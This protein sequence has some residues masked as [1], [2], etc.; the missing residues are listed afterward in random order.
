MLKQI[1][2]EQEKLDKKLLELL[3]KINNLQ[4]EEP[5]STIEEEAECE[6]KNECYHIN[7]FISKFG[8]KYFILMQLSQLTAIIFENYVKINEKH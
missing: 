6:Y 2:I 4:V 3:D 1:K 7:E 8:D 5:S